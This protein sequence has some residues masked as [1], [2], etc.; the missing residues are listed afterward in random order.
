[1]RVCEPRLV[2][3]AAVAGVTSATQPNPAYVKIQHIRFKN[4]CLPF[5]AH[6]IAFMPKKTLI[7]EHD[8]VIKFKLPLCCFRFH[9]GH[10]IGHADAL[11]HKN[12]FIRQSN[13]LTA[14][15]S[16]DLRT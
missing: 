8:F 6:H 7:G 13:I 15:I 2:K 10:L 5:T 11:R 14:F 9:V 16:S 1:M 12:K 4:I 3:A